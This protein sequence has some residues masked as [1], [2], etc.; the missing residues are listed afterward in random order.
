MNNL[1]QIIETSKTIREV[2]LK[3][4][5]NQSGS[6]Y[7]S[8]KRKVIELGLDISHFL[9]QK[10]VIE[11]L[12]NE[13]K[14][15]SLSNS[16][17]FTENSNIGRNTVK[18]RIIRNKIIDYKCFKCHINNIWNGEK[19]SLILDH[20][21]GKSNDNR[22]ENLR[23]ACPNCNATLPTHC[24]GYKKM[25]NKINKEIQ[26]QNIIK[27]YKP[28]LKARKVLRP[29]FE[30]LKKLIDNNSWVSIG[31]LYNVSDNAIRKWAKQYNL[32]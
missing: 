7:T 3:L 21:N 17:I 8:I 15:K 31:K 2:L 25:I 16:E 30:E 9:T 6:N 4:N 11:K 12:R 18:E 10:E 22:I 24:K 23:F 27:E 29:S 32:L 13:G 26:K 19:I 1:K 20:I 28:R 14:L 5:L